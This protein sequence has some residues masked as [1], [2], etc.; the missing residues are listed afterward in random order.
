[1]S[2]KVLHYGA[3]VINERNLQR[4]I[5]GKQKR[6]HHKWHTLAK[7]IKSEKLSQIGFQRFATLVLFQTANCLLLNL[8][9]TLACE[10]KPIA[11]LLQSHLLHP[12]SEKHLN[13]LLLSVGKGR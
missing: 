3:I 1:M 7:N 8:A 5:A 11:Y 12:D 9:D 4:Q 2:T 10:T 6:V 13:N